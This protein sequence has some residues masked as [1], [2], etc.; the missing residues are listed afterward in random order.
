MAILDDSTFFLSLTTIIIGF[1][2][3][4]IRT[5]YK[6]KCKDF[7]CCFGLLH[8]QRN[9]DVEQAIDLRN[10]THTSERIDDIPNSTR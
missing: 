6:S 7:H 3:I 1:G 2:A 9:V 4:I 10:T 8:I 5:L